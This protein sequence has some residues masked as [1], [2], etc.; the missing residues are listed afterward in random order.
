MRLIYL[1]SCLFSL[2]AASTTFIQEI[3]QP[4]Y[5]AENST[6]TCPKYNSLKFQQ[7]K[8]CP[9]LTDSCCTSKL[10]F[11]ED[12]KQILT[13]SA[14][15]FHFWILYYFKFNT[16]LVGNFPNNSL[17][18]IKPED[19]LQMVKERDACGRPWCMLSLFYSKQCIFSAKVADRFAELAEIYPN[20]VVA[21]V[22]V[23][24]KDNSVETYAA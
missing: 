6:E 18:L 3:L 17:H 8:Q 21:A 11:D 16:F 15:K 12:F 5:A 1:L 10:P 22:D 24:G 20:M 4:L 9:A 23:A 7:L 2:A 13:C 14:S 19:F